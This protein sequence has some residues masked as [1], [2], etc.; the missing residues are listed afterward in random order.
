MMA[1]YDKDNTLVVFDFGSLPIII[2][3]W[4]NIE[5]NKS[6]T[7][8]SASNDKCT[9]RKDSIASD[10]SAVSTDLRP[11]WTTGFGG[12]VDDLWSRMTDNM[13][14]KI[15]DAAVE[16]LRKT[17]GDDEAVFGQFDDDARFLD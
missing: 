13:K 10:D 11:R 15:R 1:F 14:R 17:D 9:R 8:T 7:I 5:E 4:D 6:P 16:V 12:Y 3:D 2:S